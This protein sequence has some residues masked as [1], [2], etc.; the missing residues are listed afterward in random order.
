MLY[1]KMPLLFS[2]WNLF[3]WFRNLILIKIAGVEYL[4]SLLLFYNPLNQFEQSTINI[5][6]DSGFIFFAIIWKTDNIDNFKNWIKPC[7]FCFYNWLWNPIA[8]I[9]SGRM[10]N[11]CLEQWFSKMTAIRISEDILKSQLPGHISGQ[12]RVRY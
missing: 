11:D 1:M 6:Q 9:Q 2:I 4:R 3:Q 5:S 7:I 10:W 12:I 8:R